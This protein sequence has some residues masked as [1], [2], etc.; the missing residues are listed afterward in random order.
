MRN[1]ENHPKHWIS[2][3]T[4]IKVM[5]KWLKKYSPKSKKSG[6]Y[7]AHSKIM[8]KQ[9]TAAISVKSKNP[10]TPIYRHLWECGVVTRTG[11]ELTEQTFAIYGKMRKVYIPHRLP[12]LHGLFAAPCR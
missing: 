12:Q 9:W 1:K 8:D 2:I 7:I 5:K 10:Q 11:I 6:R 3:K 4:K